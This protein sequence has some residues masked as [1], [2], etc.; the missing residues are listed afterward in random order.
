[1][2]QAKNINQAIL[3]VLESIDSKL[4]AQDKTLKDQKKQSSALNTNLESM[5]A[6]GIVTEGEYK[7]FS[8][9]FGE[10]ANGISSLVKVADKI[11]TKSAENI[12]KVLLS[13]GEGIQGFFGEITAEE[14][15]A[16]T[17]LLKILGPGIFKF[18]I[19]LTLA[20]PFLLI[21]PVAAALFGL[22]LRVLYMVL[23]ETMENKKETTEGIKSILGMAYGIL[24]FG[25]SMAIFAPLSPLILLGSV[26][27]GLSIRV[28]LLTMGATGKQAK[29]NVL[30]VKSILSL[31]K[32]ILLFGFAVALYAIVSPIV[33][34]GA[35]MFGLTIRLLMLA[36]GT[37]AK[38]S[39]KTAKGLSAILDLAKGILLFSLAMIVFLLVSPI[40]LIGTLVFGLTVRL[41]LFIM[42]ASGK[43][44]RKNAKAMKSILSLARG[45]LL[46]ALAMIIVTALFPI[47][48]LGAIF[49]AVA[50]FIINLGLKMIGS[51]RSQ[52]GVRALL[53][54]IIA[55]ALLALVFYLASSALTWQGIGMVLVMLAGVALVM[56][57][58]GKFAKGIRKGAMGLLVAVVPV[59]LLSVAMLIWKK[60]NVEWMD[61]GKLAATLA[62]VALI[63]TLVG[64]PPISG[65][66]LSGS[67]ALIVAAGA[68]LILATGMAIWTAA[69]VAWKDVGI[70]G[71]TLAMLGVEFGLLGLASPFILIGSA[72]MLVASAALFPITASLAIFKKAKWNGKE[73]NDNLSGALGAVVNG[74]LG[75]PMPGGLFAAIKFAAKAAAR[76]V[77]LL[78][79][80]PPMLLAA[81][82]LFPISLALLNFKKANFGPKDSANMEFAIGAVI[83]AFSLPGDTERQKKMGIYVSPWNLMLGI[84]SLKNAGTTLV[85]LAEGIQAFANLTVPI[86]EFNEKKGELQIVDRRQMNKSDFDKAAYGMGKV[87]SAIAEPFAMVGKLDKG[88]SSGNPFYDSIFGGGLVKRGVKALMGAG[89]ILVDLAKAV[90]SFANLTVSR[91]ALVG[92]GAEAKLVEVERIPMDEAMF[93]QATANM[94]KIVDAMVGVFSKVGKAESQGGW[95]FSNNY[96][97]KGIK[98]L[99]GAGGIMVDLGKSVQ[100]FA[101][102][103]ISRWEFVETDKGGE[104]KEVERKQMSKSDFNKATANMKKIVSTVMG[105]F[106]KVGKAESEGGWFFSNGYVKKGIKALT[107][108]GGVISSIADGVQKMAN[109][110]FIT[111]GVSKG[112]I[113]PTG[114]VTANPG[115]IMMAGINMRLIIST[116]MDG[117]VFAGKKYEKDGDLI[118]LGMEKAG[119]VSRGISNY[120]KALIKWQEGKLDIAKL[121]PNLTGGMTALVNALNPVLFS[122]R[123]FSPEY[124]V[125]ESRFMAIKKSLIAVTTAFTVWKGSKVT[126]ATTA[127]FRNWHEELHKLFNPAVNP[128]L[129]MQAMY[130]TKFTSNVTKLA[131]QAKVWETIAEGM[132]KTADGMERYSTAINNTDPGNLQMMDSLMTSLAVLGKNEG[133]DTLGEDIGA[134]IQE[135]LEAF[136]EKIAELVGSAGGGGAAGAPGSPAEAGGAGGGSAPSTSPSPRPTAKPQP[137][138]KPITASQIA[139]AMKSAL[140]GTTIT[141]RSSSSTG[142]DKVNF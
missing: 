61:I 128:M 50:L 60:A 51:K 129:P 22:S 88:E 46:F 81:A 87:I 63:G 93:D 41:L 114:V 2:A 78:I 98:A 8:K 120:A 19:L 74:F 32:G 42:G 73:D 14:A 125:L 79:T 37:S 17:G 76:A 58:A 54:T 3:G 127:A 86:Y 136:A 138:A 84:M 65:F 1:M 15:T 97:Q 100:S 135:G 95:F 82:A 45:I 38:D 24:L 131:A 12:K 35:V 123:L 67:A 124:D 66:V 110:Q 30:A 92:E 89:N 83:R 6:T 116:L 90:Q 99:T 11:S 134:G 105:I 69:K 4:D 52:K 26:M 103:T 137:G 13:I 31:A 122:F 18:A 55:I 21:A 108:A 28:L 107:G 20:T 23:G 7:S 91:Y 85:S 94:V 130:F 77:L 47:V 40:V 34:I 16:F 62:V 25:L 48:I 101:N 70:L 29:Q 75:G 39:K 132:N 33:M 57:A 49:F 36:M 141:V 56:Y 27:F 140:K 68:V 111:Y 126:K 119:E 80:V 43:N 115:K 113:V 121:G 142:G 104:L 96:V 71:A 106:S 102:L 5:A 117:L 139:S 10:I 9:F 64:I 44:A 59:I 72:A 53:G 112:K 109:M 133:L 118:K